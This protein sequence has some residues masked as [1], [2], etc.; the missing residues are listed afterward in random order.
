MIWTIHE[1]KNIILE[2]GHILHENIPDFFPTILL[3][4]LKILFH[5]H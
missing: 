2:F 5:K 4:N 3:K 1:S